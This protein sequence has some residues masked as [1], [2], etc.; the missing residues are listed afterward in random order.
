MRKTARNKIRFDISN[1]KYILHERF[2]IL[3]TNSIEN[4]N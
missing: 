3:L 1:V 2:G 4:K